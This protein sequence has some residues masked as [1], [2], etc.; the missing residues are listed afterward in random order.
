MGKSV[1]I[2]FSQ[3]YLCHIFYETIGFWG[4]QFLDNKGFVPKHEKF[5]DEFKFESEADLTRFKQPRWYSWWNH[6][7]KTNP[8]IKPISPQDYLK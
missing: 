7:R 6:H 5:G 3:T 8:Q 2:L 1:L 4:G